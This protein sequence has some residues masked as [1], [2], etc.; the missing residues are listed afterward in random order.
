VKMSSIGKQF[1]SHRR[2]GVLA[3]VVLRTELA[4]Y[5]NYRSES[6]LY[7]EDNILDRYAC[8]RMYASGIEFFTL[9]GKDSPLTWIAMG[10]EGKSIES[11]HA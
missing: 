4:F 10:V 8:V 5:Q 3:K 11:T 2:I 9:Q 6:C 7:P 1:M